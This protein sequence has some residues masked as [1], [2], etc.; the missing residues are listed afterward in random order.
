MSVVIL[1]AALR[2]EA[3]ASVPLVVDGATA[4][5]VLHALEERHPALRG[6]V[7]DERGRLREHVKLFVNG[8]EASLDADT[9]PDDEV[10]V[11]PAISGG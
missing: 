3:G 11:V 5:A 10:H 8:R 9:A 1:P 6:W 7:L 4:G 2:H